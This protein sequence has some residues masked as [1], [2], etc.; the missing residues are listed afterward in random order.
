ME[1]FGAAHHGV[2]ATVVI[3]CGTIAEPESGSVK[4]GSRGGG[5]TGPWPP[6]DVSG[7]GGAIL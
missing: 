1:T 7:G 2:E 4:G 5:P 3:T 6:Q